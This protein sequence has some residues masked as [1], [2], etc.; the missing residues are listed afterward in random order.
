MYMVEL[1]RLYVAHISLPALEIHAY[2]IY[3]HLGCANIENA[4]G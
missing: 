1:I 2:I 4:T 3:C